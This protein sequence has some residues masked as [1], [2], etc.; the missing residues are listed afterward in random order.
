MTSLR[1][2]A[3]LFLFTIAACKHSKV[4]Q[5]N[6]PAAKNM[7]DQTIRFYSD[8]ITE[9]NGSQ[10]LSANSEIVVNPSTNIISVSTVYNGE[11][12]GFEMEVESNECNLNNTL[13]TGQ[14]IY[15]GNVQKDGTKT[16]G[17]FKIEATGSAIV[18]TGYDP[19]KEGKGIIFQIAKW[20]IE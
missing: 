3:I 1:F 20:E 9:M 5:K 10:E 18:I 7:C 12:E 4:L 8:K 16:K 19:E 13:T 11:K 2:I 17:A 6:S 14:A 15:N